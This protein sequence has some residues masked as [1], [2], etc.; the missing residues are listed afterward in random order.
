MTR[1]VFSSFKFLTTPVLLFFTG[2]CRNLF[3]NFSCIFIVLFSFLLILTST[4]LKSFGKNKEFFREVL[5]EHTEYEFNVY[6]INGKEDGNTMLIIGGMH[7]EPAG[8]LTAD[9]YVD[10][11][12]TKGNLIIVPRA[13]FY[14]II[15]N[16]RG[17]NGDMNRKFALNRKPQ[18]YD[19]IIVE[20]IKEL[21]AKS[22]IVLNLHE[23][24][25][26]YIETYIDKLR[27]P[28][29]FGQ[30]IIADSDI[31]Y[32]NKKNGYIYLE[33]IARSVLK[34]VN[35]TIENKK[36][37]FR[38]NNHRTQDRNSMHRE[39][40]LSATY[41]ALTNLEIP[42][43][44]LEVSKQLPNLEMK[45]KH[46]ALVIN[47]FMKAFDIVPGYPR[48]SVLEPNL[49]FINIL[50]NGQKHISLKNN[51][52]FYVNPGDEIQISHIES[53]YE[54][55]I[56]A[57]IV[58]YGRI[59]DF[60]EKYAVN[61][62]ARIVIKKDDVNCG[63]V[64]MFVNKGSEETAGN[65]N[66][67]SEYFLLEINNNLKKVSPEEEIRVLKGD[68]IKIADI[69]SSLKELTNISVNFYGYK[70]PDESA[71]DR[72]YL[73]NT[74]KNLL[75][76]YSMDKKGEKYEI[77]IERRSKGY[78][79]VLRRIYIRLVEPEL[80]Y[81]NI[82]VNNEKKLWFLPGDVLYASYN[83]SLKIVDVKT[84]LP[85]NAQSEVSVN[86]YGFVGRGDG[87]DKDIEIKLDDSLLKGF[88]VNGSGKRY[89]IRVSWRKIV[90]GSIYVDISPTNITKSNGK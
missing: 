41:Y 51:E 84:N 79:E 28:R 55:G 7:N 15:L 71:E 57:D 8:Y 50:V 45:V 68:N 2:L 25:G 36:Y 4:D 76:F 31:Y 26:F 29:R 21:M 72:G 70:A 58:G 47:E 23:G 30:S 33:D 63:I 20:K 62:D 60:G 1:Y 69:S 11:S 87:E 52:S 49:K 53:N 81:I 75:P 56:T 16:D 32:S 34:K 9:K 12:L 66:V 13:N 67:R 17:V 88:S 48:V 83:D 27:N 38:F 64:Y 43:F 90:F 65:V 40:R 24:S 77:R 10:F 59:Q 85:R 39:Q 5:F 14:T 73:I 61:R 86:F 89:E 42:A 54:R 80:E 37:M 78:R 22:D 82:L 18:H 46:M 74:G 44:G 35:A 19:E 3:I 6:H